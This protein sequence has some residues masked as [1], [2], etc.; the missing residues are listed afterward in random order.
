MLGGFETGTLLRI[1]Q[2]V[3]PPLQSRRQEVHERYLPH[4]RVHLVVPPRDGRAH[5]IL[6]PGAGFLAAA[7]LL[8]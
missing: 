8:S 7:G 3:Q 1:E 4:I 5:A 2:V 6:T